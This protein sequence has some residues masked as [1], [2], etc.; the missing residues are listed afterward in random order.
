MSN[1]GHRAVSRNLLKV[2][3]CGTT[4]DRQM[5]SQAGAW[6]KSE[7][8]GA[9]VDRYTRSSSTDMCS[10][11][12]SCYSPTAPYLSALQQH[13]SFDTPSESR[14]Q[15]CHDPASMGGPVQNTNIGSM[16]LPSV[17][18]GLCLHAEGERGQSKNARL[19]VPLSRQRKI[20]G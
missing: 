16:Q 6:T 20:A 5:A 9:S 15:R 8:C 12:A 14:F 18:Q 4:D 1:K 10:A 2:N 11:L 3:R 13:E 7:L 17:L 19:T